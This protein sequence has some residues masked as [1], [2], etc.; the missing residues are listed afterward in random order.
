MMICGREHRV[1]IFVVVSLFLG[2]LSEVDGLV[3][4]D[5]CERFE[6]AFDVGR[7]RVNDVDPCLISDVE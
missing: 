7:V 3:V 6:R 5:P 1:S 4:D 2:F